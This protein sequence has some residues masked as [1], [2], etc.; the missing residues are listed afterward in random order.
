MSSKIK[1]SIELKIIEA[2]T[3]LKSSKNLVANITNTVSQNLVANVE[4]ALGASPI[5]FY[6]PDEATEFVSIANSAYINLGTV[7]PIYEQTIPAMLVALKDKK[8]PWV[9]DPVA[10]GYG[11]LRNKLFNQMQETKAFPSVIRG[12]ASE[13]I[14]LANLW[15]KTSNKTQR[16][17]G[18]E[19]INSTQEAENSAVLLAQYTKGIVA[20]SGEVD[21]ITDGQ[22][23]FYLQGGSDVMEKITGMGCS[24]GG[25]IASFL[26]VTSP[27]YATISA[28]ILYKIAGGLSFKASQGIGDFV[29]NFLNS[30]NKITE[31][32]ILEN[33]V[34]T[35]KNLSV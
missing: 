34:L 3:S 20:V 10:V 4:L 21:F 15:R 13:I 19:A 7:I 29:A 18:T 9:L 33:K 1:E 24:L 8:L 35:N 17:R 28:S 16:A 32:Q 27:L 14:T 22:D 12:N 5:M 30:I 23:A 31:S 25:A 26:T 2:L 6:M 11:E